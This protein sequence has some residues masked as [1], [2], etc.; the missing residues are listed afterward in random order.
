M[1]ADSTAVVD[2]SHSNLAL[3]ELR[4]R[5]LEFLLTGSSD[6]DGIPGNVSPV[7]KSD[8]TVVARLSRLQASLDRLRRLEGPAGATIRDIEAIRK[9]GELQTCCSQ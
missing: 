4:L 3:L 7:Q 9:C 1:A 2:D 8:D 6:L 5:R